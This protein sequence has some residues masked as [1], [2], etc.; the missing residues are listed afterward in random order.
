MEKGS[1][2]SEEAE[3]YGLHR[4]KEVGLMQGAS[5]DQEYKSQG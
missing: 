3:Q 5:R 1:E 4:R 2:V